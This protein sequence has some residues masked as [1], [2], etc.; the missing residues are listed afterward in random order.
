[1]MTFASVYGYIEY[2]LA[3]SESPMG[4]MKMLVVSPSGVRQSVHTTNDVPIVA[5]N[6][7]MIFQ[8]V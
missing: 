3:A 7:K 2:R 6:L 4:M 1:M 5:S 8:S